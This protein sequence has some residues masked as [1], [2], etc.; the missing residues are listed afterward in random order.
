MA[1]PPTPRQLPSGAVPDPARP[2]WREAA[3][4]MLLLLALAA[5]E[6]SGWDLRVS[7][8]YGNAQGFAWRDVWWTRG[9]L[10]EG[11]RG[12]AIVLLLVLVLDTW[13]P[14]APGP[15][16]GERGWW[17]GVVL[18]SALAV[19]ALK[20][21]TRSS[22]PWDLAEFGGQV[23]Y[24]P[25][26]LLGVVDGGP[27][28]CFPSGHAVSAMA[29]VGL[30]FLWRR[31]RPA[32]ARAL[33]ALVLAAGLLFGWAQL[34]RGAHHVSHSLWT[35]WLCAAIAVLGLALRPA[36]ARPAAQAPAAPGMG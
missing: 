28:H 36:W 30:Y 31:H 15:S 34:V 35:A 22:C 9:V 33:L 12:L 7:R 10:H 2:P 14:I 20:R 4:L 32:L 13:R 29:F 1:N 17:L 26:W 19:P 24:V 25:H 11:G 8:L 3:V 18:V 16:R 23:P 6:A 27:G 21:F 5:W